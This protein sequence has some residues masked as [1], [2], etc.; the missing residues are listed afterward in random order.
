MADAPKEKKRV[1]I[2]SASYVRSGEGD[3]DFGLAF[4]VLTDAEAESFAHAIKVF[5]DSPSKE[6]DGIAVALVAGVM[7]HLRLHLLS[8]EEIVARVHDFVS[9]VHDFIDPDD[10]VRDGTA[11]FF[12]SPGSVKS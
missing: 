8:D 2:L 1:D 4:K 3:I 5:L 10:D 12:V 6:K 7:M 9:R 11:R